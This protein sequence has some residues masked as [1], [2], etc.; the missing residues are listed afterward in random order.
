MLQPFVVVLTVV[1]RQR[2]VVVR[3]RFVV[4]G[5][6]LVVVGQRFV[7]VVGQA[8]VVMGHP[9]E[10]TEALRLVCPIRIK[11]TGGATVNNVHL[12]LKYMLLPIKKLVAHF[13]AA[14]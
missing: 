6:P 4:V 2:F 5:Q 14:G 8:G 13:M 9:Q 7:V 3:Q 11:L 12:K 1:G 10:G